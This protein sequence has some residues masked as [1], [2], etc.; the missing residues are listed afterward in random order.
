[1]HRFQALSLALDVIRELRTPV[2]R[3]GRRDKKLASQITSAASSVALNLAEGRRREGGDRLHLWRIAA[4]SADEVRTA[5]LVA[6]AWGYIDEPEL[7]EVLT[8]LD[9]LLAITW[10]LTH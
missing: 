3:I 1:M 7:A 4:G 10:K 5:L 8:M 6:T 2:T 9:S